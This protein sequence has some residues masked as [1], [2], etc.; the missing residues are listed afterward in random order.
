MDCTSIFR[1]FQPSTVIDSGGG[2]KVV[3]NIGSIQLHKRVKNIRLT[4]GQLKRQSHCK[5][6]LV[7]LL[8]GLWMNLIAVTNGKWKNIQLVKHMFFSF[9]IFHDSCSI[10][11]HTHK[12]SFRCG[13]NLSFRFHS[14]LISFNLISF[15]S[16]LR[17]VSLSFVWVSATLIGL[18]IYFLC[19]W[20]F[21]VVIVVLFSLIFSLCVSAWLC[22]PVELRDTRA[23]VLRAKRQSWNVFS[24]FLNDGVHT[25]ESH[26]DIAIVIFCNGHI[27]STKFT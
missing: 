25:H 19:F 22:M 7:L 5:T 24:F 3:G 15:H 1:M 6:R 4:H 8:L 26:F 9:F 18:I 12:H 14:M 16:V 20:S 11:E 13:G 23:M 27:Q 17:S 10:H 2:G 21:F